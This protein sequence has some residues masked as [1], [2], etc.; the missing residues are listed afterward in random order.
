MASHDDDRLDFN[1]LQKEL[2]AAV[3]LDARYWRENDAKIRA[4]S[5]QRVASYDEFKDLV[6]ASHLKPLNKGDHIDTIK[7]IS[8]QPWNPA[9]SRSKQGNATSQTT[10]HAPQTDMKIPKNGQEMAR[11]WQRHV[12][13]PEQRY[14]YLLHCG[15]THLAAMFKTEVNLLGDILAA[16]THFSRED[17]KSAL[18][19]LDSMKSSSRFSLSLQFLSKKEKEACAELFEKLSQLT[20][21]GDFVDLRDRVTELKV[22]YLPS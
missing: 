11:D 19:I 21:D 15:A 8:K 20:E 5:T 9:A 18:N 2:D 22:A 17:V 12:K 4:V 14:A 10:Q 7:D 13:S 16:L 3:E 1:K 6:A